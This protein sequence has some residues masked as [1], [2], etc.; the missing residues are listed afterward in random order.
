MDLAAGNAIIL[1][2]KELV[3]KLPVP[4]FE[5]SMPWKK[6]VRPPCAEPPDAVWQNP[7][8]NQGTS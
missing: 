5:P 4:E 2:G 7:S 6:R 3:M 1:I 8:W